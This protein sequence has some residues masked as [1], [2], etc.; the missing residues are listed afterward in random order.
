M[1]I[2]LTCRSLLLVFLSGSVVKNLPALAR[3]TG[4]EIQ[5]QSLVQEDSP[6]VGNDNPVQYSFLG[7][8]TYRATWWA[9][10]LGVTKSWT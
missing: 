4:L 6:G 9:A 3:D 8:P 1:A 7:N 2:N 10:A 5:V